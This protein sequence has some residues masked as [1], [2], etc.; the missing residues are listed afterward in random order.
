M[1]TKKRVLKPKNELTYCAS[2]SFS[3]KT[4]QYLELICRRNKLLR[5]KGTVIDRSK[6]IELA[7]KELHQRYTEP[8]LF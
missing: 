3:P 7:V 4:L 1:A 6:G 2:V 8:T 5:K